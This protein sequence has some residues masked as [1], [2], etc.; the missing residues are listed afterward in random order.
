MARTRDDIFALCPTPRSLSRAQDR[1]T[2]AMLLGLGAGPSPA[3]SP[4]GGGGASA[5]VVD[6]AGA[7]R[8]S[9]VRAVLPGVAGDRAVVSLTQDPRTKRLKIEANGQA[10]RLRLGAGGAA[11]AAVAP[12]GS[13][14]DDDAFAG[15]VAADTDDDDASL[16]ARGAA[17]RKGGREAREPLSAEELSKLR[18]ERNR[19]HAKMTRDRK[20][21]TTRP[22]RAVRRQSSSVSEYFAPAPSPRAC[23]QVYVAAI[24]QTIAEL[25]AR[26]AQ[27]RGVVEREAVAAGDADAPAGATASASSSGGSSAALSARPARARACPRRRR[28]PS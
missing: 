14:G 26:N 3:V 2:A 5:D 6:D 28:T 12:A 27:M 20:K 18:R 10:C 19:I 16:P 21:V 23:A 22:R 9:E 13:S 11:A 7:L 24:E 8:P 4:R 1:D 17:R 15:H 25:E